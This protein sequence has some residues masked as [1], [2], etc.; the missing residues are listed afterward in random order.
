M[1][2]SIYRG[3]TPTLKIILP[4]DMTEDTVLEAWLSFRPSRDNCIKRQID[5]YLTEKQL[6]LNSNVLALNF[7]QNGT[8][9]FAPGTYRVDLR[10]LLTNKS[11]LAIKHKK[12]INVIDVLKDGVI[13]GDELKDYT[14][15]ATNK[16]QEF[17]VLFNEETMTFDADFGLEVNAV[18]SY[19]TL[20]DK[21]SINGVELIDDKSFEDLGLEALDEMDI[22]DLW[23]KK[24]E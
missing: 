15:V 4:S 16:A 13:G 10:I 18:S 11:A 19:K 2:I 7:S 12:L 6:T 22:Y 17:D 21:P 1:A 3:T 24:G 20:L 23:N 14:L 5:Y 8:L 9:K